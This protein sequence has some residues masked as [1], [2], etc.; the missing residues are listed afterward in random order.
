MHCP[1]PPAKWAE[2]DYG[3]EMVWPDVWSEPESGIAG[4]IE[5]KPGSTIISDFIWPHGFAGA[6][7]VV[8]KADVAKELVANF[9]GAILLEVRVAP[10]EDGRQR[11]NLVPYP[12]DGPP[13]CV[14]WIP[15]LASADENLSTY[16]DELTEYGFEQTVY[17]GVEQ[18][19]YDWDADWDTPTDPGFAMVHTER[20][21]GQGMF[22]LEQELAGNDFV[23]QRQWPGAHLCTDKVR[24][25]VLARGFT[26][27][28]F[29]EVGNVIT[30]RV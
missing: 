22:V 19:D 4:E 5:W 11:S 23:R 15:Q 26:N 28:V 2:A 21:P 13:L 3:G 10:P 9:S 1:P 30:R 14:I 17:H 18:W 16:S 7:H 25:F 20:K 29:L 27:I 8:A 6:L 24:E 12:Y